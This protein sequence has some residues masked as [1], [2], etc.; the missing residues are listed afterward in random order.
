MLNR[1]QLFIVFIFLTIC[2]PN[3]LHA[4]VCDDFAEPSC[5]IEIEPRKSFVKKTEERVTSISIGD[6]ALADVEMIT[7]TQIL[8]VAKKEM[9]TT[10]LIIWYGDDRAEVCEVNV[11]VVRNLVKEIQKQLEEIVP[12]ARVKVRKGKA[13]IILDGE[14]ESQEML[15]RV[16]KLSGTFGVPS[17]NLITLRGSQQ[18]QL[19]VQIAEVSRSAE[20][21]MGLGALVNGLKLNDHWNIGIMPNGTV[22]GQSWGFSED[23]ETGTARET[24]NTTVGKITD[25]A[26]ESAIQMSSPY[27]SAFQLALH[28]V[29][30]NT[31]GILSILK[32]QGLA[33]ILASPT[34]VT[35]SGQEASFLVGGEFPI[36]LWGEG[37]SIHFK[38]FGVM[39]RFTPTVVGKETI[40]LQVN[41][42]VS[43]PDYS[44]S[45]FSGGAAVPGL[46]TRRGSTT[47]QLRDGQTFVMAGLLK[48]EERT[49]INKIPFLGD[50]PILG[51]LF[52]S[53]EFQKDESELVITVTPRLVRALN[54]NEV[55]ALPGEQTSGEISDVDFFL[56]NRLEKEKQLAKNNN[57]ENISPAFVGG[58]GFAR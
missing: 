56:L 3:V 39:L 26:L 18:V 1:C 51:S 50:I 21:Q 31:L 16:L 15:D 42:E 14:V 54:P 8:I 35:M 4:S 32:G 17:L 55:P 34:L 52:T 57:L 41:P 6:A 19:E 20:K 12:R 9:G 45:I 28:A 40:T 49:V 38:K 27:A 43:S 5:T 30:D 13:G 22:A 53:K 47:L 46:K 11:R 25:K 44:L 7:P 10:N 58:M 37:L 33:R 24:V 23:W 36:P 48:E 29:E 2:V